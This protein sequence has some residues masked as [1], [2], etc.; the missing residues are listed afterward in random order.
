MIQL[1]GVLS[2]YKMDYEI[3]FLLCVK[4]NRSTIRA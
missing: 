4:K 3:E 2:Q 1:K